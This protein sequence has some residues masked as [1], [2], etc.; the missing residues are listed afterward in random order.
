MI[1]RRWHRPAWWAVLLTLAAMM[2]FTRL[3]VWQLDRAASAR[4]VMAAFADA[5]SSEP[6]EFATPGAFAPERYPHVRVRGHFVADR[7]YLRDEQMRDGRLGVEAYA[8]FAPEGQAADAAH[9]PVLLIDRGWVSKA[10]GDSGQTALPTLPHD[11]VALRGIYA[12]FPGNGLRVGGNALQ[13]QGAWP[14]L[15]L[16]ID[17]DEIAADLGR[18]LFSGVLLL[19][20]DAASGFVRTWTPNA[21]PPERH[22]GYALQWFAFAIASIVIFV[23]LHFR[24]V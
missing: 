1:A 15:T 7:T 21:M 22:Q 6:V 20:S 5:A 24:K 10:V 18:P 14:K 9:A 3:G 4:S 8:V 11:I 2:L 19:D 23:L 17:A 12:P 16:A 13:K